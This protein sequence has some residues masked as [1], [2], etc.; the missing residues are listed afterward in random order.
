MNKEFCKKNKN[1]IKLTG[2]KEQKE[3]LNLKALPWIMT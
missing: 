2:M 1:L 3:L